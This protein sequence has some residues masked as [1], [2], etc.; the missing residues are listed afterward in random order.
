MA[1]AS[2]L[3]GDGRL[4]RA[5]IR[6]FEETVVLVHH[7]G[8][9]R[10]TVNAHR[11]FLHDLGFDC[12]TFS[13]SQGHRLK[14]LNKVNA[15]IVKDVHVRQRQRWVQQIHEV[16]NALEGPK[17]VYSFSFPSAPALEALS[18]RSNG[19]IRAW[20]CDG[21]PFLMLLTCF[22][23]YF[24]KIEPTPLVLRPTRV[25]IAAAGLEAWSLEAD[26]KRAL[27]ALPNQFPILSIRAWQDPL[28]PIAAIDQVFSGQNQIHLETLTLPEAGHIDG[29]QRFPDDYKPRVAKFLNHYATKTAAPTPEVQR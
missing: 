5:K 13:L 1:R 11:E 18:D 22:W 12:A 16:L 23:N 21:G 3:P 28:V 20:I 14:I 26:L 9:N 6:R 27:Q 25:S 2:E 17:I 7:Y 15:P 19:E 29:L 4:H 24:S 10:A 8:G